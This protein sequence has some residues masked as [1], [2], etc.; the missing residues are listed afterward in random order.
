VHITFNYM[1]SFI[2]GGGFLIIWSLLFTLIE[3]QKKEK[4]WN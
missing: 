2:W 4:I 3:K 1:T